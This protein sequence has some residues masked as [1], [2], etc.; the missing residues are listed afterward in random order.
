[1]RVSPATHLPIPGSPPSNTSEPATNPPPSVRSNSGE[2][3]ERRSSASAET[4]GAAMGA[5]SSIGPAT[6]ALPAGRA[7][8]GA[9]PQ[10]LRGLIAAFL[11]DKFA[12][13]LRHDHSRRVRRLHAPLKR[14]T[15]GRQ[16]GWRIWPSGR[17]GGENYKKRARSGKLSPGNAPAA[18]AGVVLARRLITRRERRLCWRWQLVEQVIASFVYF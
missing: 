14:C 12:R 7:A 13:R 16:R 1:M 17:S 9:A 6:A 18:Y 5:T 3:V 10:P 8:V 4:S 11:A 15:P 2:P